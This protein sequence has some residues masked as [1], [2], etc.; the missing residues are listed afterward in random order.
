MTK[1]T[2]EALIE[3]ANLDV[4][5]DW[6]RRDQLMKR[7]NGL[8]KATLNTWQKEMESIPVFADGVLKPSY[9][10]TFINIKIFIAFLRWKEA[11][12]FQD[13]KPCPEN[14]IRSGI[15]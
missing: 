5:T 2:V 7:F 4:A 15:K 3:K 13:K 11:G 12:K 9:G 14:Y 6:D 10:V 8:S 1:P